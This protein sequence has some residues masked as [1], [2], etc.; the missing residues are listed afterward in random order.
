MADES[1]KVS[2]T[3]PVMYTSFIVRN[4]P[5]SHKRCLIPFQKWQVKGN[6]NKNFI[7]EMQAAP[8]LAHSNCWM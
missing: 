5:V 7:D 1:A 2:I 4:L 8:T 3:Y 6:A